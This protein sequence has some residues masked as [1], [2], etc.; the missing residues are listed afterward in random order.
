MENQCERGEEL[1]QTQDSPGT[2]G[3][4]DRGGAH[5][6]EQGRTQGVELSFSSKGG[7]K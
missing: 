4:G 2:A 7:E 6:S 1:P 3:G 5:G